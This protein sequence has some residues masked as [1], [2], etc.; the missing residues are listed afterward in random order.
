MQAR[1]DEPAAPPPVE[2]AVG[3]VAGADDVAADVGEL[4]AAGGADVLLPQAAISRLAA[5]AAAVVINA[6]CLTV[7][8]TGPGLPGAQASRGSP[9]GPDCPKIN[10]RLCPL[11]RG[12][13]VTAATSLLNR[14]K[15][16]SLRCTPE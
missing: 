13:P 4:V 6:V 9:H 16:R 8:S 12:T 15:T 3:D 10:S 7:S 14:D 5:A 11:A 1:N 2:V